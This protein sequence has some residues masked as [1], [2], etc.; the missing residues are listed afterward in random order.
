MRYLSRH[1][2]SVTLQHS[3]RYAFSATRTLSYHSAL[4]GEIRSF[5]GKL[6]PSTF[7]AQDHSTSE[8]LRTL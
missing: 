8:L 6:S 5:G 7:S 1:S 4:A 3:L 2:H